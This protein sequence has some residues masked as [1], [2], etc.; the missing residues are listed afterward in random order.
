LT[1]G[2]TWL[3]VEEL[4]ATGCLTCFLVVRGR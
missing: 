2:G 1:S 4:S 3:A